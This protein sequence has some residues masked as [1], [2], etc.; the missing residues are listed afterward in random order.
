MKEMMQ[1]VLEGQIKQV[2][3]SSI[4]YEE[5]GSGV[6]KP[7][8]VKEV[9]HKVKGVVVVADGGG[10]LTVRENLLRAVEVLLDVPVHKI[11]VYEG[12]K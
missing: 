3:K 12:K 7:I 10:D 11:Q 6:K 4:V 2:M 1:E 8:I 9:Y 5:G